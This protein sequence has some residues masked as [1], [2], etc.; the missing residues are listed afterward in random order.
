MGTNKFT[1]PFTQKRDIVQ[2]VSN[3]R[4]IKPS[5]KSHLVKITSEQIKS[6]RCAAYAL[7]LP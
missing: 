1:T 3:V 5:A 6:R 2:D 7:L 4:P